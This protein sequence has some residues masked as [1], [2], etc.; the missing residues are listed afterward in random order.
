VRAELAV[1]MLLVS[2]DPRT[3]QALADDLIVLRDGRVIARGAPR[4]VLTDPAVFPLAEEE[5]YETVLP[6]RLEATDPGASTVRL[7]AA[8]DG[9]RLVVP[10]TDGAPGEALLIGIPARET[11]LATVEPAGLS[12]RNVLPGRVAAVQSL[13]A[14]GG[15]LLVTVDLAGARAGDLPPVATEV[16]ARAAAE[17]A[18]TAGKTVYVILK[19]AGCVVYGGRGG[20]R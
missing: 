7:G 9:P 14:D 1:P 5:G 18:L 3:V 11:I 19:T 16:T 12:A 15:L 4:D 20:E 13:A 8:G 2:H 17:L 10:R 6:A